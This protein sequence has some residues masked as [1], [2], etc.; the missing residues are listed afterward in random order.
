MTH[1]EKLKQD[2][3]E[4][5]VRIHNAIASDG[6][7]ITLTR[8]QLKEFAKAVQTQTFEKVK[9]QIEDLSIDIS[10]H[11]TLE[12]DRLELEILVATDDVLSD[13]AGELEMNPFEITDEDVRSLLEGIKIYGSL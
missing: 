13:I 3:A 4:L 8:D 12:L 10:D 9:N 7:S 5:E 6:N 1:L 11:V 2:L